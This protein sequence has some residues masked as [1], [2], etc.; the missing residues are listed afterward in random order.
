VADFA[1]LRV[2]MGTISPKQQKAEAHA[3]KGTNKPKKEDTFK[4]Q[5]KQ[6]NQHNW[7]KTKEMMALKFMNIIKAHKYE[8]KGANQIQSGNKQAKGG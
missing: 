5:C 2:E 7:R 6:Q 3:S 1:K 4:P 8:L